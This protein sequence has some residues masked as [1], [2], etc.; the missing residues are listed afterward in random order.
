[1]TISFWKHHPISDQHGQTLAHEAI[2]FQNKFHF[3]FLK[4]TP[5]GDWLAVC[6][7]AEDEVWEN[8]AVGRRKITGFPLKEIKDFYQLQ[9][10]TFQEKLL[11]EIIQAL[12]I[13]CRAVSVPVYATIFC[14]LSQLIQIAGLDLFLKVAQI[15]PEAIL[16]ALAVINQNTL[17]VIET[18]AMK[19]VKGLYY[20][21]Q[22][23]QTDL[24][25]PDLYQQ[26][27]KPSDE[28]CL[29][30]AAE[31]FDSIIFHLHGHDCYTCIAKDIPKLRLHCTFN[32][33]IKNSME[34]TGYPIIYGLPAST[35]QQTNTE[36]ECHDILKKFPH[37]LLLTCDCV[38]PIAFPDEQISLWN[39]VIRS[40]EC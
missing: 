37:N 23:M 10:F 14:P 18:A 32:S 26:F 4:L 36:Q 7:G 31:V 20:V 33:S 9:A 27:G 17:S 16:A 30:K 11:V 12:E 8:D 25:S 38:L 3:D 21:T 6:Y 2:D 5:A 34:E 19:G 24:L 22:H 29:L 13:C 1:M 15:E 35:L 40:L 39:K 28:H